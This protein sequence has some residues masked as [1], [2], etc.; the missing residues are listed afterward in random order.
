MSKPETFEGPRGLRG[1]LRM[2]TTYGAAVEVQESSAAVIYS[3]HG[4]ELDG[5]FAWL[6]IEED[7]VAASAHLSVAEMKALRRALNQ[8][9]RA[10]DVDE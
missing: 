9:I 7:G 6:R 4:S 3:S 2:N 5:P 1:F 10:W 8:A